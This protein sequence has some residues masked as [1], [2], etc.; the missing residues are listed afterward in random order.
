MSSAACAGCRQGAEGPQGAD[1]AARTAAAG[2]QRAAVQ[3]QQ[4]MRTVS[5]VGP[6]P[7]WLWWR[8]LAVGFSRAFNLQLHTMRYTQMAHKI[9]S[10]HECFQHEAWQGCADSTHVP[11]LFDNEMGC[12]EGRAGSQAPRSQAGRGSTRGSG[13]STGRAAARGR[14]RESGRRGGGA[15]RPPAYTSATGAAPASRM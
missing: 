8:L 5:H 13:L 15:G 7:N 11:C 3:Q 1:E 9:V 4:G 6:W 14:G 12:W 10:F 2:R